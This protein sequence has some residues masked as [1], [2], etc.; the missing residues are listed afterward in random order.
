VTHRS[1]IPFLDGRSRRPVDALR[2]AEVVV[3]SQPLGWPGV[4][5][6]AG[7]NDAWEVDDLMVA[8][9]YLALNVDVAPLTFEV[10][11]A[12][13]FRRVTLDPGSA[14]VCPAGEPFTHRV[15]T[16]NAY[17]LL[18]VDPARLDRLVH[19]SG[20]RVAL[21]RTYDVRVPQL[22]HLV[23]ALVV[24]ADRGGPGGPPFVDALTTAIGLQLARVAGAGA[25]PPAAARGGLAP[26]A[27]R[28]V[29]ALMDA[30]V[31]TGV[32][33]ETLAREAGL[34]PAH[35]ARAFTRSVGRP[36]HQHLLALRLERARRLL[37]AADARLSDVALRTGFADQS[38]FTRAFRR[39]FGVTP[40]AVMR[41]AGA[42]Q[43]GTPVPDAR[44]ATAP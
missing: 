16:P 14:W 28:R 9:H 8:H 13:G 2:G 18:A 3:S 20:G 15:G 21:R 12:H 24:E 33:I 7:R 1:A 44:P 25:P 41:A 34:S 19:P 42:S 27:R 40:G 23:R 11:G 37:A 35:F 38:H 4:L 30:S 26:A 29:L 43:F 36:P 6:E 22:D 5:V 17:A 32:S 31:E 10:R 39:A